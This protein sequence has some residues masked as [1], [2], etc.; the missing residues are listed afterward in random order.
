MKSKGGR[1]NVTVGM[2]QDNV[3]VHFEEDG[4]EITFEVE[5]QATDFNSETEDGEI[6]GDYKSDSDGEVQFNSLN[7][8]VTRCA[9]ELSTSGIQRPEEVQI[10]PIDK[11]A[12]RKEEEE[13]M[14]QFVEY[15]T[16]Q[17]LMIVDTSRSMNMAPKFRQQNETGQGIDN[18]SVVTVRVSRGYTDHHQ[19]RGH[20]QGPQPP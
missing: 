1:K 9:D 7:N 8:N 18:E 11:E 4:D 17:G 20:P 6:R 14:Q 10:K 16:S 15:M 5:G 3:T 19:G 2:D 12:A 13:G